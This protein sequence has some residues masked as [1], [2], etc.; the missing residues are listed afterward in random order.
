MSNPVRRPSL[1]LRVV[2]L[3]T[4]GFP[5]VQGGVETH[6]EHLALQLVRLGCAVTVLTRKPYVRAER[7]TYQG[8]ELLALPTVRN[9]SLEAILH[10]F[11]GVW[12]A[13]RLRPDVLHIHAVG[14]A[15]WTPLARLLGLK[16]VVTH[17]GPDYEREKWGRLAKQVL[18]FG[19]RAGV[20]FA[21]QVIAIAPNIAAA[22][23]KHFRRNVCV[24]PNGVVLPKLRRT[25]SALRKYGLKP[26]RYF[27]AV[28]RYV[29]EK[30][31]CDLIA[32]FQR[33]Q[34]REGQRKFPD[35]KLVIAGR[36]DHENEYGR[37]I[38]AMSAKTPGVILAGF[39]SGPPLEELYSQAGVFVLPSYYEGLPLVLLEALSYGVSCIMSDIPA[40]RAV[41]AELEEE[42]FFQPGDVDALA[43]RLA[44]WAGKPVTARRKSVWL[45]Q[46]ATDYDWE[47]I[48]ERTLGV[49]RNLRNGKAAAYPRASSRA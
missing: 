9:R 37:K 27:L 38:Q 48:A 11:I 28:G 7:E 45:R 6:C 46:L 5:G 16:V 29:P 8:V 26:G 25:V 2:M 32:A 44:R 12:T 17:H 47:R 30:G 21:N 24:I 3:G 31:F 43:R 1:P 40:N 14:P 10:T 22:I 13:W 20:L 23:Q 36:A 35:W 4:R 39:V 33:L 19:E 41:E 18:R 49:Y 34:E 15:I 42:R